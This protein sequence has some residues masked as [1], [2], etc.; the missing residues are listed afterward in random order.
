MSVADENGLTPI[1]HNPKTPVEPKN[2]INIFSGKDKR[3]KHRLATE[4]FNE[5]VE[6]KQK[7]D[8]RN[9]ER[10]KETASYSK[11]KVEKRSKVS[12]E[13]LHNQFNPFKD[14]KTTERTRTR[15]PNPSKEKEWEITRL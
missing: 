8:E 6:N 3:T 1:T 13:E 7:W 15:T 5:E 9:E 11:E 2:S 10:K 4:R 12:F 14:K